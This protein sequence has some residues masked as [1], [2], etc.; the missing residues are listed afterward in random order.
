MMLEAEAGKFN[1]NF[2]ESFEI[3]AGAE[4]RN[5]IACTL[6]WVDNL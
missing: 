4:I 3:K 5:D 1:E 6:A 2:V